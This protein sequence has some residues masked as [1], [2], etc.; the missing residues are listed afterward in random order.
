MQSGL[1]PTRS[2]K[3][4]LSSPA[5]LSALLSSSC[6]SSIRI[7]L[8]GIIGEHA[9]SLYNEKVIQGVFR[10]MSCAVYHLTSRDSS[11]RGP[12]ILSIPL[13]HSLGLPFQDELVPEAPCRGPKFTSAFSTPALLDTL[14]S[15]HKK[16][17]MLSARR[18]NIDHAHDGTH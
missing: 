11:F 16:S 15:E 3:G 10:P 17:H 6:L 1:N 14:E 4:E 2:A 13:G 12:L 18:E 5:S 9:L 8:F 7:L